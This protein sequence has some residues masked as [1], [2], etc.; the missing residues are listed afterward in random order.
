M[1]EPIL[2]DPEA[3]TR[4][5]STSFIRAKRVARPV[6]LHP[7]CSP[8]SSALLYCTTD[9]PGRGILRFATHFGGTGCSDHPMGTMG[10]LVSV[11]HVRRSRLRVDLT[12]A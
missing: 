6:I 2:Q 7:G 9:R 4:L 8:R 3:S 11:K 12:A 10:H 5:N 1:I